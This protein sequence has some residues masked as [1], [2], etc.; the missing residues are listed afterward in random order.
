M[1]P[2]RHTP[3]AVAPELILIPVDGY[4]DLNRPYFEKGGFFEREAARRVERFGSMA[5]VWSTYESRRGKEDAAPYVRGIYGMQLAF[6]G[7]RWWI[8]NVMWDH[9]REETPIPAEYLVT[10]AEAK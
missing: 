3:H 6:D 10:P 1:I 7:E 4:I 5:Q 9:E 8:V 2:V